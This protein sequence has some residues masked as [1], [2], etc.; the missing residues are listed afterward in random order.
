MTGNS[1]E[2]RVELQKTDSS[3]EMNERGRINYGEVAEWKR[4]GQYP[5]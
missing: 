4:A 3:T 5:S 2:S 1:K